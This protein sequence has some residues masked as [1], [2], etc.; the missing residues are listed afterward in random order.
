MGAYNGISPAGERTSRDMVESAVRVAEKFGARTKV[1]WVDA[2]FLA[3]NGVNAWQ[4][5]PAWV[6]NSVEGYEGQGQLS[7]AKSIK[8][9][10]KTRHIDDTAEATINYY[11]N[12][13]EEIRKK[14]GHEFYAN[15][16]KRIRG[17][18]DPVKEQ[19]VLELWLK[20]G[21]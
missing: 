6:P 21:G 12:R 4:H 14:R 16:A 18:L 13:G 8:A 3:E 17:G 20:Q 15:W 7:T 2:E 19:E 1:E 11:M 10:L 9:G 5:M